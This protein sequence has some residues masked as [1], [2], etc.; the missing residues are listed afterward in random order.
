M[1]P[2]FREISRT[3]IPRL[4]LTPPPR[5]GTDG[6][7]VEVMTTMRAMR[8][9]RPDPVPDGLVRELIEAA[10]CAPSA[11]HQQGQVFI[12]VTDRDRIARLAT[13]WG[14]SST[15]TRPGWAKRIPATGSTQ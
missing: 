12:V 11:G 1:T 14:W 15:C 7:M 8:R 5:G 9:L 10:M 6:S 3:T 13:V 4:N 2:D